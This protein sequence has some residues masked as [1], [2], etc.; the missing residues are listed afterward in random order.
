[1]SKIYNVYKEIAQKFDWKVVNCA[2]KNFA[3]SST[4]IHENILAL[5]EEILI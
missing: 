5:V 2:D 1:M 3:R 4:D